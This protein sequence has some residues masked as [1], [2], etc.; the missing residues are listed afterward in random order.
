[1]VDATADRPSDHQLQI[2][3]ALRDAD[4]SVGLDD[5]MTVKWDWDQTQEMVRLG[6]IGKQ[7]DRYFLFGPGALVLRRFSWPTCAHSTL[8]FRA[9]AYKVSDRDGWLGSIE[10]RC[11]S[12]KMPFSFRGSVGAGMFRPMVNQS[13]SMLSVPMEPNPDG[14]TWEG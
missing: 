2:L 13:R 9:G 12:C 11:A 3:K 1:M 14:P 7:R 8:E 4:G 6:W 5:P 10:C